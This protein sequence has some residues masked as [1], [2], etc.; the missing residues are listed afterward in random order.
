MTA[1]FKILCNHIEPLKTYGFLIGEIET[2][3]KNGEFTM[4]IKNKLGLKA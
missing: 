1:I 3:K 2:K 4:K